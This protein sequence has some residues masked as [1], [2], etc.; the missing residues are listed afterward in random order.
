MSTHSPWW[1]PVWWVGY[2]AATAR[3]DFIAAVIVV[4]LLVPQSLAYAMLAGLPA[5]I[6]L[7]ASI[8][9]LL[10]YAWL[11]S[12]ASL[13]VGP[14]AIASLMTASAL[15]PFAAVAAPGSEAYL[16]LAMLLAFLGGAFLLLLGASRMG[17]VANFLS[18]PVMSGFATGSAVIIILGQLKPLMGI[19]SKFSLAVA[20]IHWPTAWLGIAALGILLLVRRFL[21][22]VVGKL[23]PL[24][25]VS[26]AVLLVM[27]FDLDHKYSVQV[28][29]A[30]PSGLPSVVLQ[31]PNWD[32]IKALLVP[33]F[34]IAFVGFVESVSVARALGQRTGERIDANRELRGLGLANVVSAASMGF[35]V[36]GGFSRSAVNAAAGAK[37]SMAGVM[38]AGLLLCVLLG[39]TG[40]FERLPLAVLAATIIVAVSSL[41]DVTSLRLIW[42]IDRSDAL[43]WMVT[44]LGV[45]FLGVEWGLGLGVVLSLGAVLWRASRPHIAILGR[46]PGTEVFRNQQRYQVQTWDDLLILRVD[47]NLFFANI[48]AVVGH[49]LFELNNKPSAKTLVLDMSSVSY[50]DSSAVHDLDQLIDTLTTRGIHLGM[51]QVKGP[52]LDQLAKTTLLKKLIAGPYASLT[53]AVQ[54][55]TERKPV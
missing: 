25:V 13:A 35:P 4:A 38:A 7:Y 51:A 43:A 3:D 54:S 48:T 41:V 42:R 50:I 1:Q 19:A 45:L 10:A 55:L 26:F 46:L 34:T 17:F 36:T 21:S 37:S 14:V 49:I 18:H 28:V 12:S 22:G 31:T 52:V 40:L 53:Q 29:G 6:G 44:V 39:F 47:E 30:I 27:V 9:P 32:Q 11:G 24:A 16:Q 23:A 33:A 15:T 20:A 5:Y 8:L 2:R